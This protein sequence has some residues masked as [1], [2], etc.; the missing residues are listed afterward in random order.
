M[1][2]NNELL[3]LSIFI[4]YLFIFFGFGVDKEEPLAYAELLT[5]SFFKGKSALCLSD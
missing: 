1:E 3:F 4:F 5:L 2:M